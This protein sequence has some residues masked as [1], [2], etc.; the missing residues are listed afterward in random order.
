MDP[1]RAPDEMSGYQRLAMEPLV[2]ARLAG[3]IAR[4]VPLVED[5]LRP[6]DGSPDARL[7]EGEIAL[8]DTTMTTIPTR[9]TVMVMATATLTDG[10]H[11]S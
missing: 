4:H 3:F 10:R 8:P 1:N 6:R 2:F 5:P 11:F 9:S 7:F